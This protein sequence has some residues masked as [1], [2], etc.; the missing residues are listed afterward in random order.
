MTQSPYL[1]FIAAS[2]GCLDQVLK[3]GLSKAAKVTNGANGALHF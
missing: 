2:A 1:G 3:D